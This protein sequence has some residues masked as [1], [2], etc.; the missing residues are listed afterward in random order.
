[1]CCDLIWHVLMH[2][3]VCL[4]V[5][6]LFR[7]AR[8]KA[9]RCCRLKWRRCTQHCT[10]ELRLCCASEEGKVICQRISLVWATK[11]L[12]PRPN[13]AKQDKRKGKNSS[14]NVFSSAQQ[15]LDRK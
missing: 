12:S 7:S 1:M 14:S 2:H 8:R 3:V 10:D 4:C 15:I 11:P 5:V 9:S 13:T 6:C